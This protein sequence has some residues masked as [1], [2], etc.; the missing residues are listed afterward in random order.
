M[1]CNHCGGDGAER[2]E[3]RYGTGAAVITYLC[4][5]CAAVAVADGEI[6]SLVP[7]D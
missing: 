4:G 1:K 2:M 3:V 5:D 6:E 7:A